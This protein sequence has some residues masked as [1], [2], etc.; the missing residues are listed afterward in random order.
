M[1]IILWRIQNIIFFTNGPQ[2]IDGGLVSGQ[3]GQNFA[4]DLSSIVVWPGDLVFYFYF[5]FIFY[6]PHV[7]MHARKHACIRFGVVAH[8]YAC[9]W[10]EECPTP[11]WGMGFQAM[12]IHCIL[13]TNFREIR[14]IK[15]SRIND[16]GRLI[17]QNHDSGGLILQSHDSGGLILQNHDL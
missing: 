10:S 2:K 17:L 9:S 4:A 6:S 11:R 15:P 12:A 5:R 3:N 14:S 8:A 16:S 7:R 13:S 1:L